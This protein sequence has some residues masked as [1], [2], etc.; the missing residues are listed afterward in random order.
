[1]WLGTHMKISMEVLDVI[2]N[3][4][5]MHLFRVF[6]GQGRVADDAV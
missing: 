1:L 4:M 2:V 3:H 5:E 6:C